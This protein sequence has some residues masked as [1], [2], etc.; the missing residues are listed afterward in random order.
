[1]RKILF[2]LILFFINC[3]NG[4]SSEKEYNIFL[5]GKILSELGITGTSSSTTNFNCTNS[6]PSFSTL[7][8]AGATNN[9]SSCHSGSTLNAGLDITTR[10]SVLSRI[11]TGSPENSLLYIK[12][13]SGSMKV[14]TT[15]SITEAVYCWIK[16]GALQ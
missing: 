9:C 1:M 4:K 12:I 13:T 8:S 15:N 10:S 16:G 5:M 14:H 7:A 6:S 2:L 11:T 3:S